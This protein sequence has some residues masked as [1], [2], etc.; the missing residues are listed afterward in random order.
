[1][2]RI[3]AVSYKKPECQRRGRPAMKNYQHSGLVKGL[4]DL[5]SLYIL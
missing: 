4:K 5:P 3:L 2:Q 1:M